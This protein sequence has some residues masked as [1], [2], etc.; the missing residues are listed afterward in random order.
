MKT[1]ALIYLADDKLAQRLVV[2]WPLAYAAKQTD[3]DE[4]WLDLAGLANR[5]ERDTSKLKMR[6]LLAH[7]ICRA[8]GTV[9]PTAEAFIA[10]IAS[11]AIGGVKRGR[12]QTQ[13]RED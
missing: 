7:G 5:S 8:D 6:M 9:D 13:E 3:R 11:K 1:T 12:T 4:T 2:A 10:R